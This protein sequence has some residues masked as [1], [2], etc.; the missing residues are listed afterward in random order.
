MT[1]T[2]GGAQ[3]NT[4]YEFILSG[5]QVRMARGALRMGVR[6]LAE[7]AG[8]DKMTVVRIESDDGVRPVTAV[9]LKEALEAAGIFF[10]PPRDGIHGPGVALKPGVMI[11]PRPLDGTTSE[12]G[13]SGQSGTQAEAWDNDLDALSEDGPSVVDPGIEDMRAFWRASPERWAAMHAST[14]LALLQEMGLR[15]L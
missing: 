14:Q 12:A 5:E 10:I 11:S 15:K 3:N 9:R 6:E 2:H 4:L 7:L 13:G 1:V 8:V